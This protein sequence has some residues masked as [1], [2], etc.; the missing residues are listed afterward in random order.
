MQ[1]IPGIAMITM[2]L[3]EVEPEA[4]VPLNDGAFRKV[5]DYDTTRY[6]IV[7]DLLDPE[8]MAVLQGIFS[9]VEDDVQT[10]FYAPSE[11]EWVEQLEVFSGAGPELLRRTSR[12]FQSIVARELIPYLATEE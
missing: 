9:G 3:K 1:E 7:L 6:N 11:I 10:A 5:G 12:T 2:G 4:L 8:V